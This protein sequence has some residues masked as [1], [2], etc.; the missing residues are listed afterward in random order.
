[1][2][3]REDWLTQHVKKILAI[4]TIGFAYRDDPERN[5]EGG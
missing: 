4:N 5:L 1:M 3:P 2:R